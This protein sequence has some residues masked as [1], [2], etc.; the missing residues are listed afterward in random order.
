MLDPTAILV[1][2]LALSI[3]GFIKGV[4]GSGLPQVAIPVMAIFLGV[5]R[6]VVIMVIPG[7]VSNGFLIWRNRSHFGATR[8]LPALLVAGIAGAVGGTWLLKTLDQ[9]VLAAILAAIVLVYVVMRLARPE[10]EL[11]PA[12]TRRFA[13]PIGFASG[14]LQGASGISG[15]LVTTWLHSY[16]LAPAAFVLSVTTMF[17]VFSLAQGVTLVGLGMFSWDR[18]LEGLLAVVPLAIVIPLG[19]RLAGRLPRALFDRIVLV[20]LAVSAVELLRKTL[21]G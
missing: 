17:Q 7:I 9:R 11:R 12:T 6:S 15:P 8:D 5:E 14:A 1:I 13:A 16:R 18:V 2:V 3:G 4:T 20:L 10:L 19:S 21:L